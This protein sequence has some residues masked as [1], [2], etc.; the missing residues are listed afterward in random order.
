MAKHLHYTLKAKKINTP[1][2]ESWGE[3]MKY[4]VENSDTTTPAQHGQK[5]IDYFNRT[6]KPDEKA[7]VYL[8]AIPFP[9]NG[10]PVIDLDDD[11]EF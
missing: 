9:D 4:E 3:E 1:D 8:D 5:I 11:D 2:N 6:L 10:T 7:R